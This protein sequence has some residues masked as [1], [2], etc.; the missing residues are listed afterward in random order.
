MPTSATANRI[1]ANAGATD[2]S[3]RPSSVKPMP[4]GS[5]YGFGLLSVNEPMTGCSSDAVAWL[6]KVIRPIWPKSSRYQVLEDRIDSRQNRLHEVVETVTDRNRSKNTER[7]RPGRALL[8][9]R[10]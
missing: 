6:A 9:E 3:S 4:S 2:S 5:E 8:R 7:R 10:G 1:T